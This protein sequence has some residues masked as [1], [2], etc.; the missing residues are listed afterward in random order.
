PRPAI[1]GGAL[2][3]RDAAHRAY[4]LDDLRDDASIVSKQ[5]LWLARAVVNA[6]VQ[7]HQAC[8]LAAHH[9][10]NIV[11]G[12][13]RPVPLYLLHFL[14]SRSN[15][16]GH[17]PGLSLEIS[18]FEFGRIRGRAAR[19]IAISWIKRI[20]IRADLARVAV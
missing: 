6:G 10:E 19:V 11:I 15:Q 16:A 1:E 2:S 7:F 13:R 17:A 3:G 8:A 12:I 18:L 14:N 4:T 5:L 20:E 9:Q